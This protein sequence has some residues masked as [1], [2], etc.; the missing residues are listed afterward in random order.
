MCHKKTVRR[1]EVNPKRRLVAIEII[2]YRFRQAAA[3]L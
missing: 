2:E 3:R 1:A